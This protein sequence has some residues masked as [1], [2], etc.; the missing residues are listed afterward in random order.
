MALAACGS[1][2]EGATMG[3]NADPIRINTLM[4]GPTGKIL[5]GSTIG[6]APFCLGGTVE[7]NFL[8]RKIGMV[9]RTVTCHDGT[10]RMAFDPEVTAGDTTRG[11]WR[12][13]SGTGTYRGWEGSGEMSMTDEPSD[14]RPHAIRAHEKCT[15]TVTH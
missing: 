2:D 13:I 6:D 11:A 10:L 8:V 14:T 9:D 4:N 12:I 3:G 15:G 1:Q 5:D 7:D